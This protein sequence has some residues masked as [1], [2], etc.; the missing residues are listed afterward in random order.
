MSGDNQ[1]KAIMPDGRNVSVQINDPH[2]DDT[3]YITA[4]LKKYIRGI[5]ITIYEDLEQI[6][7]YYPPCEFVACIFTADAWKLHVEK[8]YIPPKL[9][10]I[11]PTKPAYK[12]LAVTNPATKKTSQVFFQWM[13]SHEAAGYVLVFEQEDEQ[14]TSTATRFVTDACSIIYTL[15]NHGPEMWAIAVANGRISITRRLQK[16]KRDHP[17][18]AI[19]ANESDSR[20]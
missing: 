6:Y 10:D 8:L 11:N 4:L 7:I 3:R 14:D 18:R 5:Q 1:R 12:T 2:R 16:R 20:P 13:H 9:V 15:I 19:S 17:F